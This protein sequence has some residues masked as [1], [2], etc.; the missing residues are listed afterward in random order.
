MATGVVD[1]GF[2]QQVFSLGYYLEELGET[3]YYY[4][5]KYS[6]E[7]QWIIMNLDS[8]N[9]LSTEDQQI[10]QRVANDVV[11]YQWTEIPIERTTYLDEWYP[12]HGATNVELTSDQMALNVTAVREHVWPYFDGLVG[13]MLMDEVRANA[14]NPGE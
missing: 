13:K 10:I 14:Q 11:D 4:A 5:Y 8:W 3:P 1:C 9:S 2:G 6:L 12:E 7:P